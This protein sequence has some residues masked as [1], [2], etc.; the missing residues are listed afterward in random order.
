VFGFF[1]HY[2]HTYMK[3]YPPRFAPPWRVQIPAQS[4]AG[5][6]A[7]LSHFIYLLLAKFHDPLLIGLG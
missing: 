6:Y 2:T 4:S 1:V 3:K 5:T 7:R